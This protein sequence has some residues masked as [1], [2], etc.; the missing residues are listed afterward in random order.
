MKKLLALFLT[1]ITL[2]T[3]AMMTAEAARPNLKARE[4]AGTYATGEVAQDLEQ[5]A[6]QMLNQIQENIHELEQEIELTPAQKQYIEVTLKKAATE[7]AAIVNDP[8]LT[9][10]QKQAELEKL[11]KETESKIYDKLT[12]EQQQKY[13][14]VKGATQ[15][16]VE[17]GQETRS[18]RRAQ[19]KSEVQNR[20]P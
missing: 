9:N 13:D 20:K 2:T 4:A 11:A 10:E 7:A 1:V 18:G 5:Q 12:P 17:Q 15:A 19:V 16:Q 6:D 14:T 8:Y 3:T